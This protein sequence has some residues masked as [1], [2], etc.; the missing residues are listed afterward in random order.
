METQSRRWLFYGTLIERVCYHQ[1][2]IYIE[3]IRVVYNG[4]ILQLI[5]NFSKDWTSSLPIAD[6]T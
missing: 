6:S 1:E 5:L 4:K 3:K 2:I